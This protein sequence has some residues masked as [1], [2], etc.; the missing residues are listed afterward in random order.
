M[1]SDR[2]ACEVRLIKVFLAHHS[3]CISPEFFLSGHT[4]SL[5]HRGIKGSYFERCTF[6]NN[7]T[8][9]PNVRIS[10]KRKIALSPFPG[11]LSDNIYSAACPSVA[12]PYMPNNSPADDN[13]GEHSFAGM[14]FSPLPLLP[15]VSLPSTFLFC[16]FFA[17]SL[18]VI[19]P[20]FF[21]LISF[22][23]PTFTIIENTTL[24]SFTSA[25][26]LLHLHCV[27]HFHIFS[28]MSQ[29][30]PFTTTYVHNTNTATPFRV[31]VNWDSAPV[32]DTTLEARPRAI[33]P[34]YVETQRP[35]VIIVGAGIAGLSLGVL[36]QMAG[37]E[38]R[39][40]ER[41]TEF[42]H[43]GTVPA[44][45]NLPLTP[46]P[47]FPPSLFPSFFLSSFLSSAILLP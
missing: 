6:V 9:T 28:T 47:S 29:S 7:E 12:H 35:K 40:L 41:V 26:S 18:L 14:F 38:F 45:C 33:G 5:E 3:M 42:D 23:C 8:S 15:T 32:K 46:I 13:A 39:I 20:P 22:A 19:P 37:I 16:L 43:A 21:L 24:P 11:Y 25:L 10:I 2:G 17:H 34:Q 4:L 44:R 36:L 30:L 1:F 31:R 27:I